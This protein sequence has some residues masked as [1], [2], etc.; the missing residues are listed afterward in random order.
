MDTVT[1]D[2]LREIEAKARRLRVTAL[3][4]IWDVGSGHC[5]PSLS[6]AD[7]AATLYAAV[8][9]LRPG[10]PKWPD[11]DR[12]VLSK[13]HG[14]PILYAALAEAGFYPPE[15]LHT[16]RRIGGGLQG[17]P[18][19]KTT[20]GLEMTTGSL[21]NGLSA[22]AG[23]AL[24]TRY[25]GHQYRVYVLLGDGECQEGQVWEAAMAASTRK[26]GN[27]IAIVDRNGLQQTGSTENLAA[28]EPLDQKW[29]ACGWRVRTV[30]G[31]N[32]AQLL[33]AFD[34]AQHSS[35][36]P[37][38]IIARTTKGKGVSFMEGRAE[39]HAKAMTAADME[40]AMAELQ[41]GRKA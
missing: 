31:H 13:G 4:M 8:L 33:D 28:I 11:R 34:W 7:I 1:D 10:E 36:Q 20:P 35:D 15:F 19:L 17:H 22:G 37:S 3:Q 38:A 41:N 6:W 24:A 25:S 16:F 30:D 40:Q 27:L 39:W 23:M 5:G 29:L 21:G 26:L 12:F 2:M 14:A 9:H 32:V 18:D